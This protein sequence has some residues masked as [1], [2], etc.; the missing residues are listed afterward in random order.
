MNT[1][2]RL[3]NVA[4]NIFLKSIFFKTKRVKEKIATMGRRVNLKNNEKM[5]KKMEGIH[6]PAI[7]RYSVRKKKRLVNAS[8]CPQMALL[9]QE[10][11]LKRKS[12]EAKM[13]SFSGF[14]DFT[15][16]YIKKERIKSAMIKGSLRN[17]SKRGTLRK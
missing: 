6:L 16:L 4:M 9:Y 10:I 5:E 15:V 13:A 3:R 2:K 8:I 14:F 11:G 12:E 1:I 17:E 7:K